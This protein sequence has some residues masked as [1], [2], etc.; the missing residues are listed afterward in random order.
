MAFEIYRE[1]V[2]VLDERA[3]SQSHTVI[4]RSYSQI[5]IVIM[6]IMQDDT[7]FFSTCVSHHLRLLLSRI[8]ERKAAD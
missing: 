3:S 1:T 4:L 2:K 5:T 6:D 8:I 7:H